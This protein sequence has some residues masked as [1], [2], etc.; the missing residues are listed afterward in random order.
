MYLNYN[1]RIHVNNHGIEAS[2]ETSTSRNMSALRHSIFIFNVYVLSIV[3][4]QIFL[5]RCAD[6]R[7]K[8]PSKAVTRGYVCMF[9]FNKTQNIDNVSY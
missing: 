9:V 4:H 6:R 1:S 3:C 7:L 5:L 2:P 8:T